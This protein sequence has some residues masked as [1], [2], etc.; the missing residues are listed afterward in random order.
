[1]HFCWQSNVS[2]FQY[3]VWVGP[4]FSSKEQ[5]PFNFMAAVTICSGLEPKKRKFVTAPTFSPSIS[6]EVMGPDVLILAL[7]NVEF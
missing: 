4:S 6:H 5:E 2:A 3:A 1:M 7:L